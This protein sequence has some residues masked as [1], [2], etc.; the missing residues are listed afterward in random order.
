M[1]TRFELIAALHNLRLN[2][3]DWWAAFESN[4]TVGQQIIDL[5]DGA[6]DNAQYSTFHKIAVATFPSFNY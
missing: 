1:N 3:A 6:I 2:S 5:V 4:E